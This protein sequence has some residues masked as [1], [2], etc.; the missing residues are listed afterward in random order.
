MSNRN[1]TPERDENDV[2]QYY[3]SDETYNDNDDV[4]YSYNDNKKPKS[5][6]KVNRFSASQI[7]VLA[8]IFVIY[9]AVIFTAA[10]LIFY[11]P[12]QPSGD[13]VP[14]D[15]TVP[16]DTSA[17][18]T[19]PPLDN[20]DPAGTE[21]EQPPEST[22]AAPEEDYTKTKDGVYNI[23][24]VGRDSAA[25]LADVTMIVNMDT[26]SNTISIMQIPRDTLVNINIP[27][28]KV[29]AAYSTYVSSAYKAGSENTHLTA[30]ASYEA[31]F[32]KNLCINIHHSVVVNLEAFI[33]IVDLFGGVDLYVA[34]AMEYSDPEQNL[35]ISIGKGYQHLDGYNSMCFVRYRSGYVQ[36]D[37]GRVNAQ[38][39]FLT[40]FFQKVKNSVSITNLGLITEVANTIFQNVVTDMTISDMIFY[41]KALLGMDLNAIDMMTLPG[42]IEDY[43]SYYVMNRA[44][45]LDIVN[46]HF[47]IYR[48][49]ISDLIFDRNHIFCDDTNKNISNIYYGSSEYVL[50]G[51]YNAEDINNE[52]IY[53]PHN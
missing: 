10:W 42:N 39:I 19:E 43:S 16:E 30:A 2:S 41:G 24:V 28:N 8:I 53:I 7:I 51:V 36:A 46:Q 21:T 26:V 37:L 32:E 25:T 9:T 12:A 44:A 35:Y 52:S 49:D 4:F 3:P 38:K 27:T 11:K 50:D 15:T 17:Q 48:A 34:E 6:F 45:A 29:N 22:S 47:N 33:T 20:R 5:K 18:G 1:N 40:A 31:L 23:L 14:F 13:N